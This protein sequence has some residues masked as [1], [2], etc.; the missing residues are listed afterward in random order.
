MNKLMTRAAETALAAG[1][2]GGVL[3]LGSS[4]AGA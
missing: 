1:V 2:A 4:V 3:L